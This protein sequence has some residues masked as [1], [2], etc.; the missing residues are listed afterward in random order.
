MN[1]GSIS[2]TYRTGWP[3]SRNS[4]TEL[5]NLECV[6]ESPQGLMKGQVSFGH[7]R[8]GLRVSVSNQPPRD[9]AGL[10]TSC[11]WPGPRLLS[12]KVASQAI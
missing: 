7:S 3:Y 6:N 5:L 12:D 4:S 9:A 2:W 8:V 10:W 11:G 1:G